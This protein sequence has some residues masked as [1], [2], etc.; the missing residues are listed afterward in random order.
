M[1]KPGHEMGCNVRGLPRAALLLYAASS[2]ARPNVMGSNVR[3]LPLAALLLRAA[4]ST[5]QSNVVYVL[6]DDLRADLG[7]YG[8]PVVT[9]HIDA[10]AADG[11]TF[12]HAFC[13]M[14]VCSPSRQSFMTGLRPDTHRVW[15]FID[16]NPTRS[17]SVAGWFRD[18]GYA[19][20]G[21]GKTFHEDAGAWN[22]D[23]YWNTTLLPYYPYEANACPKPSGGE[24]GGHC[25][26]PDAA[27]YD[28]RLL[29]ATLAALDV[30]AAHEPFFLM[31]GFRDPHAPWAAPQRM[32]DLYDEGDIAVAAHQV[33]PAGAP[34]IAWSNC[35]DVRLANGTSFAYGPETAV[36]DWVARDQRRAYDFQRGE[37][38]E[39]PRA[40]PFRYYAAVSYVDEHVGAIVAALRDGGKYDE[41]IVVFHSDHGY[42]LGEHGER[43]PAY[44][45]RAPSYSRERR[46]EKKSNFDLAVRVPLHAFVGASFLASTATSPQLVFW[47]FLRA[48]APSSRS[49]AAAPQPS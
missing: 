42:H 30:A 8:L 21:L 10:L 28:A 46:W 40:P 26:E 48:S 15:N 33:L 4:P 29:N 14:S 13:Q 31:S 3:G 23:A 36:P 2:A 38:A 25:A 49:A 20:L 22:A 12:A 43:E 45:T 9:P 24:G 16:A 41:S 47:R 34:R 39:P 44:E 11:L 5:T 18:H 7:A 27:I 6:S 19:A 35:L 32:Y 37:A 1:E 17:R